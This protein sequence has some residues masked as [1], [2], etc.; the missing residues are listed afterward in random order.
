MVLKFSA[1]GGFF[2]ENDYDNKR[3]KN[4]PGSIDERLGTRYTTHT[5]TPKLTNNGY[6]DGRL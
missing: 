1:F 4:T 2:M 5:R 6:V 3:K